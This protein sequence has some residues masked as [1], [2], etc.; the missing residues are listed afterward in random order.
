MSLFAK[1]IFDEESCQTKYSQPLVGLLGLTDRTT[2]Q[3]AQRRSLGEPR[4][5]SLIGSFLF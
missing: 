3:G 2:G 5:C 1:N 4:N